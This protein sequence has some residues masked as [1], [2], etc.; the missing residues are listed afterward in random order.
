[1][2]QNNQTPPTLE[3]LD[4]FLMSKGWDD[5][6]PSVMVRK[7]PRELSDHNPLILTTENKTP[8]KKLEF[9]FELSW[10][11]H[12][13]FHKKMSE[14]WEKAVMLHQHMTGYK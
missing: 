8:L 7:L 1:M 10:L 4:R 14:L 3:K 12:P 13:E 6:F 9:R 5:I 2:L 11:K